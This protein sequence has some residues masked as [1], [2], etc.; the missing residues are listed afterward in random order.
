VVPDALL[1]FT[2][3][4]TSSPLEASSPASVAVQHALDLQLRPFTR[5]HD[6]G[7]RTADNLYT[8]RDLELTLVDYREVIASGNGPRK[9]VDSWRRALDGMSRQLIRTSEQ[10]GR[11]LGSADA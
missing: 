7:Y 4:V 3:V 10:V 1:G 9:S 6:T 5:S 8:W 11:E 2:D